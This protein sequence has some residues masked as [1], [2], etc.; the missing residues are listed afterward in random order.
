MLEEFGVWEPSAI[1]HGSR[2]LDYLQPL[3]GLDHALVIHGNYLSDDEID[4]LCRHPNLTVV[5][6]PRTHAAFGHAPHPW[7]KLLQRGGCVAIGTDSR[8]SNPDLS[9]WRELC[10]L[11]DQFPDVSP[12]IL[13]ELGTIRGARA[14]GLEETTGILG[15]GR[16]ADL[17]VV[18]LDA[19]PPGDVVPA[20]LH[21]RNRIAATM[22]SGLWITPEPI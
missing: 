18:T 22:R 20:L 2:P 9:L 15:V 12:Q 5:Y 19:S 3:T 21:H 13:L 8:A 1:P 17:T 14:L 4:F 10:F 11:R 7:R 16:S 6:C